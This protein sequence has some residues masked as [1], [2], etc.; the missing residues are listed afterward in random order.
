MST[1]AEC[2]RPEKARGLCSRHYQLFRYRKTLPSRQSD[3]CVVCHGALISN[4]YRRIYCS[5][6]CSQTARTERD[7]ALRHQV[8]R[9]SSCKECGATLANKRPNAI[10]CSV[11]C[12]DTWHN[13]NRPVAQR[14]CV[15]C[16][17]PI[18]PYARRFC[19]KDCLKSQ[20][21]AEKYGLSGD[22]YRLLVEQHSSCAVCKSNEWG[23]RGPVIDHD[24]ETGRVRGILCGRCNNALGLFRDDP[25]I[26]AS[27]I[28]YLNV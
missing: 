1:C 4:D 17:T 20:Q 26:L 11:S 8:R 27:A 2:E 5:E 23:Q 14:P 25:S 7:R 12:G 24:H 9:A 13:K 6:R 28:A 21:R 22:G 10:F 18:P 19:S 15:F 3:E 16:G